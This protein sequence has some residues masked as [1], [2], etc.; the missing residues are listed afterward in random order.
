VQARPADERALGGQQS[1]LPPDG[2]LV[3]RG[4]RQIPS[5]AVGLNPLALEAAA[6]LDLSAH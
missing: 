6:A 5:D 2:F 3:Q 1:L 4:H